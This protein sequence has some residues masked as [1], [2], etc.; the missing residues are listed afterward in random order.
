MPEKTYQTT[1]LIRGDSKNAVRSIDLTRKELERLTGASTQSATASQKFTAAFGRADKAVGK[2]TRSFSGLQGLIG[3]LGLGKLVSETIQAADTY[4]SLQGQLRLVTDSQEEL[5]AVY[6]D[7]LRLS[8]ETGV[9]TE[10]TVNLYARLARSTEELNLTN[11]ELLTITKA[12][13]QSFVVSGSSAQEAAS[14]ALQLSQ[15]LAAGALQGEELK[16]VME[17]NA[18]LTTALTEALG[19]NRGE[20][21]QWG[22][23][24]KLSAEVVSKAILSMSDDIEADFNK[25]PVTISRVWQAVTNDVQ[26]ALGQVDTSELTDG[27]ED[28]REV[29]S[30]PEFKRS[31]TDISSALLSIV[32]AGA[33][34]ITAVT[35]VTRFVSES[36][37]SL[38]GLAADD[39]PRM[40]ERI[41][42]LRSRLESFEAT[43]RGRVTPAIRKMRTELAELEAVYELNLELINSTTAAEGRSADS[44]KKVTKSTETYISTLEASKAQQLKN[45]EEIEKGNR[46]LNAMRAET[47]GLISD[48]KF[49]IEA[50]ELEGRAL[51]L[52]TA[53]RQLSTNAT[54]A[55]REEILRLT[56]VLY[57][58]QQAE[59]EAKKSIDDLAKGNQDAAKAATAAWEESR[60]TLSDFFFEF[61]RDGL[62][63]FDTLVDGFKAM[64]VKMIAE[65]A[66]NRIILGIGTAAGG[67]G[68]S[69]FA[70]AAF[71]S[72][73]VPQ[74]PGG[75]AGPAGGDL[76][77]S[78]GGILQGSISGLGDTLTK[79]LF[80]FG[81]DNTA[82]ILK[83]AGAVFFP[84][85]QGTT[86]VLAG[87]GLSAGAG[88]VGG[89]A[90]DAVF[91]DTSGLGSTGGALVGTVLGGPVGAAIGGFVGS[92]IEKGLSEVFG[93]GQN[94]GNNSGRA[95]FDLATGEL[96]AQ[97]VGKSFDQANVDQVA[98]SVQQ[99]AQFAQ[100]I[101][102]SNFAGEFEV[103][104]RS[105]IQFG[106]RNFGTDEEAF[107]RFAFEE[108]IK[109]ATNVSD[110]VKE[111]ALD[112]D[113]SAEE[114]AEYA[115]A[116]AQID[117]ITAN[118]SDQARELAFSYSD[119][120]EEMVKHAQAL[121]AVDGLT[122]DLDQSL[123]DL[124]FGFSGTNEQLV[125]FGSAIAALS[126]LSGVNTAAQAIEEF[127][128]VQP[129][130]LEVYAFQT[131]AINN[132]IR[133]YDG[134]AESADRLANALQQN[135]VLAYEYALAIQEI[136]TQIGLASEDQAEYIRESILSEEQ[137]REKRLKERNDLTEALGSLVDPQEVE[138]TAARILDLNRQVFNS[139]SEDEQ[140][141]Q[142]D[143][144]ASVAEFV[145]SETQSILKRALDGLTTDQADINRQVNT[146]L[147]D[148]AAEF[149]R[150]ASDSVQAAN[151]QLVASQ[152]FANWVQ[153]LPAAD[154]SE[155]AA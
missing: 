11:A 107:N 59:A 89:I 86:Q 146:L 141:R 119:S 67:M 147:R 124:V 85:A 28:L 47:Q 75:G 16:S 50:L 130:L 99:I 35:G 18:A 98:A 64:I 155:R 25:M 41:D 72:I 84:G 2:A 36:F 142:A 26:D 19:I 12:V 34:A 145:G 148:A 22:A 115:T 14:S 62:G 33:K 153:Q 94:N 52:A 104:N 95:T 127:T 44:K 133:D 137:L 55:E 116:I 76:L 128:A 7:A 51:A 69:G 117:D 57:D 132:L 56:G 21:K 138:A 49:E 81:L 58:K 102:G 144:F 134:S 90:G 6:S 9:A 112:F 123:R 48:L 65:A 108:V 39:M 110:V 120:T 66:A 135:K 126:G 74:I 100:A 125:T 143:Q 63:A 111:L 42:E 40:A 106:D 54:A 43:S 149:Q 1:L 10:A 93:F 46:T 152:N 29:I 91:G 30:T 103:G 129:S 97:G 83:D 80:Q 24:G 4:A 101:G 113:G 136:G 131:T 3:A 92:G 105:G 13:N 118:A 122:V 68:F 87:A 73:G 151:I 114:L 109:Q 15:G 23:D 121:T 38:S 61:A 71:Q 96:S 27:I 17:N 139:L 45:R 37:A 5:N 32:T 53:E 8:N 31:I 154:S 60:D 78:I 20:L 82:S 140:R 77:S 88:I 150:A 79:T 70:N